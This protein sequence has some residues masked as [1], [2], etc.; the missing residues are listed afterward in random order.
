MAVILENRVRAPPANWL[1]RLSM[2]DDQVRGALM[3]STRDMQM[4][5]RP[6]HKGKQYKGRQSITRPE[7]GSKRTLYGTSVPL[8]MR[9]GGATVRVTYDKHEVAGELQLR[10]SPDVLIDHPN[11]VTHAAL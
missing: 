5:K 10:L 6:W 3:A 9:G 8:S 7:M 11:L 4:L 2:A 1:G